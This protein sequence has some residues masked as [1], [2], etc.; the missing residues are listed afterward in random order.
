MANVFDARVSYDDA[1]P[2]GYRGGVGNLGQAAGG[3]E[4]ES[5]ETAA[6][7]QARQRERRGLPLSR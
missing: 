3:A 4:A 7:S 6:A 2:D 5:E 1:D